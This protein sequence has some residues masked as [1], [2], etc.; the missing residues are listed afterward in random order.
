MISL[1]MSGG[2][3]DGWTVGWYLSDHMHP[4]KVFRWIHTNIDRRKGHENDV[5][6]HFEVRW[7]AGDRE[8]GFLFLSFFNQCS[9]QKPSMN[10]KPGEHRAYCHQLFSCQCLWQRGNAHFEMIDAIQLIARENI[11][12]SLADTT[13]EIHLT[14]R[15]SSERKWQVG[16]KVHHSNPLLS[17]LRTRSESLARNF[18]RCRSVVCF[19]LLFKHLHLSCEQMSNDTFLNRSFLISCLQWPTWDDAISRRNT[20]GWSSAFFPAH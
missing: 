10:E 19:L 2:A 17:K 6:W 8:N 5:F 20:V 12:F 13:S 1:E 7:T 16:D 14:R 11:L 18:I 3:K 9:S 4:K 15:L